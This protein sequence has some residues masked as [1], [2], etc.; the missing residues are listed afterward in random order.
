[1]KTASK[2]MVIWRNAM[3]SAIN[4]GIQ[5]KLFGIKEGENNFP[6]KGTTYEFNINGIPAKAGVNDIGYGEL[7]V[8]VVLWPV[9][10]GLDINVC[11]PTD[12]CPRD[13]PGDL[14]A[15][16]FLE[17]RLGA[18]LQTSAAGCGTLFCRRHRMA[19]ASAIKVKPNGYKDN[20]KLI[21]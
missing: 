21:I 5:Q 10:G 3:I 1:M 13:A 8:S 17:R 14:V 18:W 4:A 20:G 9:E 6:E 15:V 16:G 11:N 7:R 2:R 12:Y 19:E